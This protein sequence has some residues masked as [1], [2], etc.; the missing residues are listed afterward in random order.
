MAL[1]GAMGRNVQ[2]EPAG[3]PRPFMWDLTDFYLQTDVQYEQERQSSGSPPSTYTRSQLT[4][5]P[6]LGLGVDGSVYHPNLVQFHLDTELGVS[7]EDT[8]TSPGSTS[9]TGKFLQRYHGSVD[10][11]DQK[12]YATSVFGDKDM[13]YRDYDFFSRVRIDSE[14]CGGRTGYLAGPL[15]FTVSVQHFNETEENPVRPRDF[16][17]DTV[18]FNTQNHRV[19]FDGDTRLTYNVNDFRRHDDGFNTTFGLSQNLNLCDNE[20]FGA[21][22]K[23]RLASLVNYSSLSETTL[24]TDQ[25]ILQEALRVQHTPKL[26]SYSTYL[27]NTT[28]AGSS[29]A[30]TH[31]AQLGLDYQMLPDL[32][33][34]A[35][36]HGDLTQSASPGSSLE[37]KLLGS[38]LNAQYTPTLSSWAHLTAGDDAHF[39]HE[40]RN[41]SG[42]TQ[43]IFGEQHTLTDGSVTLLDDPNVSAGSIHV[44]GD[45]AHSIAYFEGVD[46]LVIPHGVYTQIQRIPGGTI[47]NG[48]VVYVDYTS[49]LQGSASYDSI[50]NT[51]VLRLDFWNGLLGVYGRWSYQQYSGG[52][53][54]QLRMLDDKTV[55]VDSA[56]RGFRAG[57]EYETV[58]SNLA[59]YDRTRFTQSAHFQPGDKTDLTVNFDEGWTDFRDNHLRHTSYGFITRV[60]QQFT[61]R[62]TGGAEGGMRFERGD[63]FNRDLA[64][65]RVWLDW[66]IGKLSV[67]ASYEFND[68][69][70]PSDQQ[71]RNYV[72]LRIRRDF[73]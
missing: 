33:T 68:E 64:T 40:D 5:D 60:Q 72:S 26:Q 9:S 67:Q 63:T 43:N 23:I 27:F 28:S 22:K 6:V 11:L 42:L 46:Y 53:N 59:P 3:K 29:D 52:K 2:A 14:H 8:E 31:D 38:G 37:T 70:H 39:D 4:V 48:S 10:F 19:Q 35:D 69:S 49:G 36:V 55:G 17:Q 30:N 34:G 18:S 65:A 32:A 66:T 20:T 16:R 25:L 58:D 1:L 15:P 47:P 24:P 51:A 71:N 13:T 21:Q 12:P 73:K 62:L 56:W 57:A 41:A 54:L 7:W 45:A 44:W 61:R 50:A